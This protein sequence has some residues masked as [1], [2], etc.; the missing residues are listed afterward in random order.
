[1]GLK[2]TVC[3]STQETESEAPLSLPHLFSVDSFAQVTWKISIMV[4]FFSLPLFLSRA[5]FAGSIS[6]REEE[7]ILLEAT[8]VLV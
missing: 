2:G 5:G 4:I 8:R 7:E 6:R 3:S 1:M